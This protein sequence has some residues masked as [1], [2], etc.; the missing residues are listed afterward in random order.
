MIGVQGM[1]GITVAPDKS[2]PATQNP[3]TTHEGI[4][5]IKNPC[6][7]SKTIVQQVISDQQNDLSRAPI[8]VADS[9]LA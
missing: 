9:F 1:L 8:K 5:N 2:F 3:I 6:P 4:G 7:P